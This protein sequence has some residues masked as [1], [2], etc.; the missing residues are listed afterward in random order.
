MKGLD[1][2]LATDYSITSSSNWGKRT[3]IE[4]VKATASASIGMNC[5]KFISHPPIYLISIRCAARH[6]V[7]LGVISKSTGGR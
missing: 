7:S 2:L 4:L 6:G 3:E 5:N 1:G